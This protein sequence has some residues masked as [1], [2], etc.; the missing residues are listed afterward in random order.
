MRLS[1][2]GTSA[3]SPA[4]SAPGSEGG[5]DHSTQEPL[6]PRDGGRSRRSLAAPTVTT[7]APTPQAQLDPSLCAPSN[8]FSTTINNPYF[9]LPVGQTWVYQGKEEGETIGLRI[10]VTNRTERFTFGSRTVT[11]R[12]VT[13]TE[14]WT[15][16]R[17]GE[18]TETRS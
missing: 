6:G 12:V 18:S 5:N 1:G 15:R 3:T 9:P 11:T 16:T 14:W 7:G 10:T 2:Q 4:G 8:T 13:E 17:M